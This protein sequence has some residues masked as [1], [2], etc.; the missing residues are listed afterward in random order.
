MSS[1]AR[2][3][4]RSRGLSVSCRGEYCRIPSD[5]AYICA[6]VQESQVR[7]LHPACL[8]EINKLTL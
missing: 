2:R 1:R 3:V 5:L 7:E 8:D 4:L 6:L